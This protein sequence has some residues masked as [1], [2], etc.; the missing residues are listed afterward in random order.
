MAWRRAWRMKGSP[1]RATSRLRMPA[2]PEPLSSASRTRRPVSIRPKVEALTNRLSEA[3]RCFSQCPSAIFSAI[4]ASAVSLSGMRSSASAR[5]IRMMPSSEVSPYSCMKASTPPCWWRLARAARTSRP[6]SSA[7][8]GRSSA[9]AVACPTRPATA[10]V[11][12]RRKA[13]AISSRTAP[14]T[15]P[16]P[17]AGCAA[18]C[19]PCLGACLTPR[20]T[21]MATTIS[22]VPIRL[23]DR[24]SRPH[25]SGARMHRF[26]STGASEA[27]H[28]RSRSRHPHA[29]GAAGAGRRLAQG[30][31][32]GRAG[33]D[34]GRPAR[35]PPHAGA[36]G[37]AEM[38]PCGRVDLRQ[39][40]AVRPARGLRALSARRGGR[41]R[42]ARERRLRCSCG[43]RTGR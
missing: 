5:H 32:D 6:A 28:D 33:A 25:L 42:Q 11:S 35:G 34:H 24:R 23:A 15:R 39:P 37:Q 26:G 14:A 9:A 3:P 10:S 21:M 13:A 20:A 4:S 27:A 36:A 8:R 7:M 12:S 1:E 41:P 17:R 19:V 31:R 18:Q 43:R 2:G 16:S 30:R 40:G 38:P 29:R 22:D